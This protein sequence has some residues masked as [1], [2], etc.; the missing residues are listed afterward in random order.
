[1]N[2]KYETINKLFEYNLEFFYTLSAESFAKYY[3]WFI[4]KYLKMWFIININKIISLEL[5]NKLWWFQSTVDNQ[6]DNYKT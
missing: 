5:I 6:S 1:M 4:K 2:E 3:N